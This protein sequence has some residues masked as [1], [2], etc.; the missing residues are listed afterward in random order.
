MKDE[1]DCMFSTVNSNLVA[2]DVMSRFYYDQ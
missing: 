2:S 1:K